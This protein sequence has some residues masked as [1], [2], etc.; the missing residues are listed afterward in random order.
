MKS[1]YVISLI[2]IM[3]IIITMVSDASACTIFTASQNETVLV[4]NN[5][6]WFFVD[7]QASFIPATNGFNGLVIFGFSDGVFQGG[8]N[9][10]GLF[11][12]ITALP[13]V[14]INNHPDRKEIKANIAEFS[15]KTCS[16][17]NEV[18]Q[19]FNTTQF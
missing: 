8:M 13:P 15:L 4:G 9:D 1:K 7:S 3:Y 11:V 17:V 19:L 5:E 16:T 14:P 6:D 12:D 10:K 18:I 2:A